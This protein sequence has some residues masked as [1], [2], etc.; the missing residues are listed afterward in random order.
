M[1]RYD[2]LG[3]QGKCKRDP[4]GYRDDVL[5][6]L[7]HYNALHGLF[8]LKPGKDFKAGATCLVFIFPP[9]PPP[10]PPLP[11]PLGRWF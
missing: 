1:S 9:F 8:M 6:Q 3:L 5:M 11:P 2:L 7:Q 10:V 4:E